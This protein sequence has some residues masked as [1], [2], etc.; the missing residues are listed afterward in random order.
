MHMLKRLTTLLEMI[1]LV[2]MLAA[3]N[4]DAPTTATSRPVVT[5]K[6]GTD[7][8]VSGQDESSGKPVE[9]GV[10][11]AVDQAIKNNVPGPGYQLVFT[12]QD[13]VG[14]SGRHDP[15]VGAKNVTFLA[16]DAQVAG[17]I[18]PLNS[19]VALATMPIANVAPIA[20]LSPAN[21]STCLT[22]T[23]VITGCTGPNLLVP[24]LRPTGKV[25]YFRLATT[26]NYQGSA[27]AD[28]AYGALHLKSA[29]VI[30]DTE[31]YGTGLADAF[32]TE[33]QANG[34]T[35]LGHE[36]I[37]PTTDYNQVLA[38]IARLQPAMIY[39]A[40]LDSTGGIAIARQMARTPGLATTPLV[41][42][43]GLQTSA[44][45]RAV[46][47][48]GVPLYSTLASA[49]PTRLPSAAAFLKNFRT[50]YGAQALGAYSASGYDC[51]QILLH[52]IKTAIQDGA[53]PAV[54]SSDSETARAFRQAVIRAIAKTSYDG[55]TG[56]QSFDTHGDTMNKIIT[57]YQLA[58]LSGTPGWKYLTEQ[59]F[60]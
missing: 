4:T 48:K 44:F 24:K 52:A 51:A 25:T 33:F 43:G 34:G 9:N 7:L 28:F 38:K 39:F 2:G 18:G 12:P 26:D 19:N 3:C 14:T 27:G 58:D 36:S 17:I 11:L 47:T 21:T 20:L 45:T 10:R 8:P 30:D 32:I 31:L 56:Y 15:S 23:D 60:L 37:A 42:G 16:N 5:I 59:T 29:Y 53:K 57:I 35:V 22:R 55:V 6:I 40:G 49:D 41:G 13:D 54:N 50:V 46:G 1:L